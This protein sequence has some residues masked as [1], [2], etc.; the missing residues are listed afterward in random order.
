M[1]ALGNEPQ[2]CDRLFVRGETMNAVEY[3]NG[4]P[5]GWHTDECVE[6][7]KRTGSPKCMED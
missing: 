7:W 6:F 3:E 2:T 1:Q 5:G 4:D